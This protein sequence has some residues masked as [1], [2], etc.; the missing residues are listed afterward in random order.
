[1]YIFIFQISDYIFNSLEFLEKKLWQVIVFV[2]RSGYYHGTIN[3]GK[4]RGGD[5]WSFVDFLTMVFD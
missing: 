5:G 3:G 2:G 1:M 4:G